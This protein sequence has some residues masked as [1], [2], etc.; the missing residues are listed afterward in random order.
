MSFLC[1]ASL[2]LKPSANAADVKL[3]QDLHDQCIEKIL[4]VWLLPFIFT[5]IA[6]L[7]VLGSLRTT[8]R[9]PGI[10]ILHR[11]VFAPAATA[12]ERVLLLLL[13]RTLT[14]EAS[15]LRF[16]LPLLIFQ[17][18]TSLIDMRTSFRTFSLYFSFLQLLLNLY[19]A[20]LSLSLFQAVGKASFSRKSTA[21]G[22]EWRETYAGLLSRITFSWLNPL[23]AAS[24]EKELGVSDLWELDE[25]DRAEGVYEKFKEILSK[26]TNPNH[27]FQPLLTLIHRDLIIMYTLSLLDHILLFLT[28]FCVRQILTAVSATP[29]QSH[30][31]ILTAVFSLLLVSL[32]RTALE[33]QLYWINRK[34][35]ARLRAA[36][37]A[38]VFD[39]CLLL[40]SRG[41]GGAD[42]A[43]DAGRGGGRVMNL[44]GGD[45]ER[46]LACVR[47]S[48]YVVSV[49]VLF[50]ACFALLG[51]TVGVPGA[52]AGV[53]ALAGAVPA[54]GMVGG[55]IKRFRK[56]VVRAGDGRLSRLGEM[57]RG[58]KTIKLNAWEPLFHSKLRSSRATEL[59][60]LRSFLHS[61]IATQ[62]LWRGSPLVA[63][64]ATF[65]TQ[66]YFSPTTPITAAT[67]FTV[68][69]MY[70]NVL[71]YPLFVVPKLAVAW[72]EAGVALRRIETVLGEVEVGRG[73]FGDGVLFEAGEKG[74][75]ASGDV[76][77]SR[78]L[79]L[80]F[81]ND[82][83]FGYGESVV[84]RDLNLEFPD[85]GGSLTVIVGP[86][87]CGKS[88]MLL[89]LLGELCTLRGAVI[90]PLTTSPSTLMGPQPMA[91]VAQQPWLV[92]ATVRENILFGCAVDEERYE[93][94]LRDC[95]LEEEFGG[96]RGLKG[97]GE[98][99]ANLSGGQR[100]RICLARAVYSHAPILL[101]DDILSALDAKTSLHI[102]NSLIAPT[103]PSLTSHR[104]RILVTGA[105][106]L[107]L[108][109][110][111]ADFLVV[112]REGG[113]V[114]CSG[115]MREVVERAGRDPRVREAFE[116]AGIDLRGGFL[117]ATRTFKRLESTTRSP[118]FSAFT[119]AQTGATTIRSLGR[120]PHVLGNLL[121]RIDEHHGAF[122][123]LWAANR[124]LAV[125]VE[126]VGA[127]VA[128]LV[129]VWMGVG[130]GVVDV[131][132]FGLALNY[133]GML[134]D[135]LT[136]LVRNSASLE[137]SMTSVERIK[138]YIDME[139]EAPRIIP[140]RRP[141]SNWPNHGLIHFHDLEIRHAP[142]LPPSLKLQGTLTLGPAQ[143]VGVVGRTGSG[144]TTLG[145]AALR[146][147]EAWRGR[148]EVDGIDVGEV[149]TEDVRRRIAV[150]PQDP[151]LFSG[152][153]REN[154]D[155]FQLQPDATIYSVLTR[156]DLLNPTSPF[157]NLDT[158][159][160]DGGSNISSGHRQLVSVART[161]LKILTP[162]HGA[163]AVV[164]SPRGGHGGVLVMDEATSNLDGR[165]ERL[166]M[167]AVDWA[168][169][170]ASCDGLGGRWTVLVVA[171]RVGSVVGLERVLVLEDGGGG[172]C[173][174]ED[175]VPGELVA[176]GRGR[177]FELWRQA[178]GGGE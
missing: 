102:L 44:V 79:R 68:L 91:L 66:S 120:G 39:K 96:E 67:A 152:T 7:F 34:I 116:E 165:S 60:S 106:T 31:K 113:T 2:A 108:C 118:I 143:R 63:S 40:R 115:P 104:T 168:V 82:A 97:V 73:L 166:V 135:V 87:G 164:T 37:V 83:T 30:L 6:C 41:R 99:G 49:P 86:T 21:T 110:H 43:S 150:I 24:A 78:P 53:L 58:I 128:F 129:G 136:W 90:S 131:G 159:I 93:A 70:N 64:A 23:M 3:V 160:E 13:T 157:Q 28:P 177:F 5:L 138:D 142:D 105:A 176:S 80:A 52:V 134:T 101:L 139:K 74:W 84:L 10:A 107:S 51:G 57:L 154:L 156:L 18:F 89:A 65:L 85:V 149:G 163:S 175:G 4:V 20:F 32:T 178:G 112:M 59:T 11:L 172:G 16:L 114:A 171:H 98:N 81:E 88:S 27:L 125:R 38:R 69:T 22:K 47:L 162:R 117:S 161:L 126:C 146:L 76:S 94:V 119:E 141:P 77:S 130:G 35:D 15:T 1:R 121:R 29:P 127:G 55:W 123:P 158:Q 17:V 75:G 140:S 62:L 147:V 50:L 48:H 71:R 145:M 12:Y 36:M 72:M 100:Q 25:R 95:A 9:L 33:S 124:W 19:L 173:V 46:V 133:A 132:W 169:G 14:I 26:T 155:P 92:N 54:T 61:T 42:A 103:S 153:L 122:L 174:V 45:V 8:F 109:L 167:D 170:E 148:I 137:M 151:F 111:S 56:E 144:K